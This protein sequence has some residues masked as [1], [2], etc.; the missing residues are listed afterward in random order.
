LIIST[1]TEYK[2]EFAAI[3][4]FLAR[5][6]FDA[7]RASPNFDDNGA[8]SA[9]RLDFPI[10]KAYQTDEFGGQSIVRP[11]SISGAIWSLP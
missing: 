9:D 6:N 2:A 7:T 3:N 5:L 10:I 4:G 1:F 11:I 8:P